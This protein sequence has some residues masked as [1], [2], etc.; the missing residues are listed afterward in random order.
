MVN[1]LMVYK[2]IQGLSYFHKDTASAY[3]SIAII[4]FS[5]L[6]HYKNPSP[7]H[8]LLLLH[9]LMHAPYSI[10]YH[11]EY[12]LSTPQENLYN[13]KKDIISIYIAHIIMH[14]AL[15]YN[16]PWCIK[17]I[18]LNI[19]IVFA[20]LIIEKIRESKS[21]ENNWKIAIDYSWLFLLHYIP[22]LYNNNI[23]H[24]FAHTLFYVIGY[25]IYKYRIISNITINNALMHC[26]VIINNWFALNFC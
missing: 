23:Y 16:L 12:D 26:G 18:T 13:H 3:T 24:V 22:I 1:Y 10:K 14:I 25:S 2:I 4:L 7:S 9:V 20:L 15:S 21:E 11:A 5:L 8:S 19:F 17:I 6:L